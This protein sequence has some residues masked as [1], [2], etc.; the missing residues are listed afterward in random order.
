MADDDWVALNHTKRQKLDRS[1]LWNNRNVSY[2]VCNFDG[3]QFGAALATVMMRKPLVLLTDGRSL[4]SWAGDDVELV[5]DALGEHLVMAGAEY[6]DIA[7]DVLTW[8]H[9]YRN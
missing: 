6:Q 7:H 8:M 9:C 2:R 5:C 3:S 1:R 4:E